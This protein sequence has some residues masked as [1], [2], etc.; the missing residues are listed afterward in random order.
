MAAP[1]G[2]VPQQNGL[3]QGPRVIGE[4]RRRRPAAANRFDEE[5]GGSALIRTGVGAQIF[6]KALFFG[7]EVSWYPIE[8][9]RMKGDGR[10][11]EVESIG[12]R[13]DPRRATF[14]AHVGVR[15]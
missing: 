8:L 6:W 1:Y 5:R 4:I 10:V 12:D 13:F 15:L 7:A 2:E 9:L 3:G 11:F 14:V